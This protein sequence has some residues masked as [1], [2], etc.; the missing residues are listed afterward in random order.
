M[1][2]SE[3][4]LMWM[5]PIRT[6]ERC[7]MVLVFLAGV[8]F[9]ISTSTLMQGQH[10]FGTF[11]FK[12]IS[13]DVKMPK[14][15]A[16]SA[17][18][19]RQGFMWFGTE[20][21]LA[22][23]NGM[24][25][26][27]YLLRGE[28]LVVSAIIEDRNGDIWAH[29]N[30]DLL[31]HL[32]RRN[33]KITRYHYRGGPFGR[34]R[35]LESAYFF[36]N[37]MFEDS[38]GFIWMGTEDGFRRFDPKAKTFMLFPKH[39]TYNGWLFEVAP[40]KYMEVR[41]DGI[42]SFNERNGSIFSFDTVA[43]MTSV[44]RTREGNYWMSTRDEGIFLFDWK[45]KTI[46][47]YTYTPEDPG[48]IGNN[49]VNHLM[50]DHHQRLWAA[51]SD[52]GIQI[53]DPDK[54]QFVTLQRYNPLV[55]LPTEPIKIF[56]DRHHGVWV[57][58]FM[59]GVSHVGTFGKQFRSYAIP[60]TGRS[61]AVVA[62]VESFFER[63]DGT[64]LFATD[65]AGVFQGVPDE[66]TYVP[67]FFHR[68]D[69][70][71]AKRRMKV[72]F[73]KEDR[74]G[75]I[76]LVSLAGLEV[77]APGDS[78]GKYFDSFAGVIE[79]DGLG[80]LWRV[81]PRALM[82]YNYATES[83]ENK[84]SLKNPSA[85]SHLVFG[86]NHLWITSASHLV[87]KVDLHSMKIKDS[88]PAQSWSFDEDNNNNLWLLLGLQGDT[89]VRYQQDRRVF[90]DTVILDT[91][92]DHNRNK[93]VLDGGGHPWIGTRAGVIEYDPDTKTLKQ[94]DVS[95]GL[96]T[97]F[98]SSC[99]PIKNSKG[100][101]MFGS[102]DGY[103][104]FHPDS[105]K[106]NPRIPPI[107][108]TGIE[109]QN[110]EVEVTNKKDPDS[111]LSAH[112]NFVKDI[113]LAHHQHDL[114][115]TFAALDYTNPEKNQYKY[116][117]IGYDSDTIETTA[118]QRRATYTN[119]SPGKYTFWVTGS[120]NDGI[121]NPEGTS[122]QIRIRSP[123]YWSW[124]S[125]M[126]YLLFIGSV[127]FWFYRFQLKRQLSINE[128]GRLRELDQ[129]KSR[130]YTNITHEFR[131]P[132]TIILGIADQLEQKVVGTGREG[133]QM[134][135]R[136]GN[137][138]LN[139]VN[140][141]LDLQKV[142][143]N[144]MPVDLVQSDIVKYLKYLV[145]SF[146]PYAESK[147]ID[148]QFTSYPDSI[149]LDY[150]PQKIQDILS[151]LLSNAIKF[152][153][154]TGTV[155]I[156]C[157]LL[158]TEEYKVVVRD[159]GAGIS[160]DA[161]PHIFDRFYQ[162]D[163]SLVRDEEGTGIGL[164]LTKE[165]VK[166]MGGEISANSILGAGLEFVVTLPVSRQAPHDP[167]VGKS[168]P[169]LRTTYPVAV[170]SEQEDDHMNDDLPRILIIEDNIDV[171]SYMR[172]TLQSGYHLQTTANGKLGVKQAIETIPDLIVSDVMMPE[173]DGYQ[174]CQALKHNP[175]TSHIPIILLTAKADTDA[176]LEG[177]QYGADVY[178]TKPFLQKELLVRITSL[179]KQRDRLQSHYRHLY[180]TGTGELG[181]IPATEVT[182]ES[183]FIKKVRAT[184]KEHLDDSTFGVDQLCRALA[185][186]S[187]QLYRKLK[188]QTGRSAHDIMQTIRLSH[189]K[190]LLQRT[191]DTI[192][193]VAYQCGFS[194]SEYFS[195][196]FKK[197]FGT[198]PSKFRRENRSD[199]SI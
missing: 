16:R 135:K 110:T 65:G 132:L 92:R 118:D 38:E 109:I 191:E 73:V 28:E 198:A 98:Q 58:T 85:S 184:I 128:V 5:M 72:R 1:S 138:L 105:I 167:D 147:Q 178:L 42:A 59:H 197:E 68:V 34:I 62:R 153:P 189:G 95:D 112:I 15:R 192:A 40:Q 159:T 26:K 19:D 14:F 96:Q 173:M 133:L 186:S 89:L 69:S 45:T 10:D 194:D 18:H 36:T 174:V 39:D 148:L 131:T 123:W 179:L 181:E 11:P 124:W 86:S 101:L 6:W 169:P 29:V 129:V 195:R 54:K 7:R 108:L 188:A 2:K 157:V 50:L 75:N 177:L 94:Y 126:I 12:H 52:V 156:E 166:L 144:V 127:I 74:R 151:N 67:L 165:L 176:R 35:S 64:Y 47:N 162:S 78:D 149:I 130:L 146:H 117:L 3:G 155:L 113:T 20:M 22:C 120:N 140:Q 150:D 25:T 30:A 66:N 17:L 82:K 145:E 84:L 57:S 87:Y 93:I 24:E 88:L 164:A 46:I 56:T 76:W 139:L 4:K 51:V 134:I 8:V 61:H 106:T 154:T 49:F 183:S 91:P 152:T 114:T 90:S 99:F 13:D 83:F 143:A 171:V 136:N 53:F 81:S 71:H 170:L 180:E 37:C 63:E 121:W 21:S 142:E 27:E 104:I 41:R 79:V 122:L 102:P 32:D 48:N 190:S 116:R 160:P 199:Q 111:P 60:T 103:T 158:T 97:N 100:E 175:K 185:M 107:F 33:D 163:H 125:Q 77:F 182:P 9:M 161:L 172:S 44:V 31:M 55:H 23:F 187:S 137:R 43:L 70:P 80:E 193:E 141:M 115:F 168:L 196:V 119:L